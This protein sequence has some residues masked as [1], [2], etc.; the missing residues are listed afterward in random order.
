MTV[1]GCSVFAAVEFEAGP[2]GV[3]SADFHVAILQEMTSWKHARTRY[4]DR[5]KTVG[6]GLLAVCFEQ[7]NEISSHAI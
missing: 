6:A 7:S 2:V 4:A 5:A 3:H 1:D